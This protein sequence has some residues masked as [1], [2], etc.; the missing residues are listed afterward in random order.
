MK[1]NPDYVRDILL[2]IEENTD[3]STETIPPTHNELWYGKIF[4][5]KYFEYYDKQLLTHALEILIKENYIECAEKPYFVRGNLASATIIGLSYSGHELL[6]NIRNDTVWT[7]VKEKAMTVGGFSLKSLATTAG[8][9][10]VAF[11][12]NPNALST[13]KSGIE[14]LRSLFS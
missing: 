9:L 10:S 7:V 1:L 5:D 11:M 6:D 4:E 12:T 2:Y 3:Y 14:Y 13:F 8:S